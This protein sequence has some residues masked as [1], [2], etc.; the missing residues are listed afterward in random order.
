M[1]SELKDFDVF[2]KRFVGD[3]FL[4]HDRQLYYEEGPIP[5]RPIDSI[6]A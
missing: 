2:V 5:D 1:K 4:E 6:P 3:A